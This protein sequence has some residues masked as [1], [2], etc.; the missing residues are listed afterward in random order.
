M[1]PD[2]A[3]QFAETIT[4]DRQELQIPVSLPFAGRELVPLAA[5]E[6]LTWRFV[7]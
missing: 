2:S 4:L 3:R 7:G 1:L 6:T 5:G